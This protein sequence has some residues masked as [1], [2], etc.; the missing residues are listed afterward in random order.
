MHALSVAPRNRRLQTTKSAPAGLRGWGK[1]VR[2]DCGPGG[3][4]GVSVGGIV[5]GLRA[6]GRVVAPGFSPAL[7]FR[8]F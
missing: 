6:A 3:Q 7:K 1:T 5:R 4:V 8:P 2:G